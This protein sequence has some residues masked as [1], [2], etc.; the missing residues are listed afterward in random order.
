MMNDENSA[1]NEEMSAD[2]NEE[3]SES[4]EKPSRVDPFANLEL[5]PP[6]GSDDDWSEDEEIN[7]E[8]AS[9][10]HSAL[11]NA[12]KTKAKKPSPPKTKMPSLSLF[13][14]DTDIGG[15]SRG[16]LF[17]DLGGFD[18]G[19]DSFNDPNVAQLDDAPFLGG[20]S[21]GGNMFGNRASGVQG[22]A[23]SPKLFA[24]ASQFPTCHQLRCWKWENGIPVGLGVIDAQATEEDFVETFYDAMP[25]PTQGK[26]QFKMRP[27]DING[28]EMGQEITL[29][30]SEHHVAL[31][32]I[33]D[34]KEYEAEKN[35]NHHDSFQGFG[36]FHH[37]QEDPAATMANQMS[38]AYDRMFS[39]TEKKQT[40]LERALEMERDRM[41]DAEREMAQERI[42]LATNTAQGIQVLTER[43]MNDESK[44]A[45]RALAMQNEQS[46]MLISTLTSIFTQQQ[47]MMTQYQE[48]QRM[49]DQQRIE[50]ERMRSVREREEVEERRRRDNDE[51][52]RRQRREEAEFE[53]KW[54]LAEE[55]RKTERL[56]LQAQID[57]EKEEMRTRAQSDSERLRQD[58]EHMRLR[59]EQDR[60]HA[61]QR[62]QR[63]RE[64]YQM[65]IRH[66]QEESQRR[67][68]ER[69]EEL[70][71][72]E[73]IRRNE[74]ELRQKQLDIQAQRDRE[75]QE[76]LMQMAML[77]RDTQRENMQRRETLERE[78]RAQAEVERKRQH[79]LMLKELEISRER[80]KEHTQKMLELSK[81]EI[82]NR[83]QDSFTGIM[84]KITSML[85]DLG[86]EPQEVIQRALGIGGRD[87]D[88]D[89]DDDSDSKKSGG[90][91][92]SKIPEMLG[93]AGDIAK[94]VMAARGLGGMMGGGGINPMVPQQQPMPPQAAPPPPPPPP[95]PRP[96]RRQSPMIEST[97]Q[98][99]GIPSEQFE[100][101]QMA[102]HE[103]QVVRMNASQLNNVQVDVAPPPP[104]RPQINLPLAEQKQARIAARSMVQELVNAT[105]D[106]WQEILTIKLMEQPIVLAY[107]METSVYHTVTEAGGSDEFARQFIGVLQS[108][109]LIPAEIP[110]GV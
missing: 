110:M 86:L 100:Q 109:G 17:G 51:Y 6:V 2:N 53:Q 61:E 75:H 71:R 70:K 48:Q 36:G 107:I 14:E 93:A 64:E 24:Q 25:R 59:M 42:D 23:T 46:Q 73:E 104:Q 57:K 68:R 98:D 49:A 31:K 99:F 43:M 87:D 30:I 32:G 81:M 88:D 92:L 15:S 20:R 77:E 26:A 108:S 41:R 95:R 55:Q 5:P 47:S 62:A 58:I 76:R 101:P 105:E 12:G 9:E 16:G 84:P 22:R 37:Q 38:Q 11:G 18:G 40:S 39:M 7:S 80:D 66:E 67:E 97:P 74:F 50:Q 10:D 28:Q 94:V 79:E 1:D 82:A 8:M 19:L 54:R 91:L 103:D 27:I 56:H 29:L 60:L 89:D 102:Q 4:N 65:K 83:N 44:R 78:A 45:E 35:N 34:A 85:K 96:R 63:E 21:S 106:K 33:R 13:G 69:Q 52:E 90:G 72:Q 3:A